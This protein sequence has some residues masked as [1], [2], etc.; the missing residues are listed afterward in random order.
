MEYKVYA[1]KYN[2]AVK[3]DLP[4]P[5]KVFW[6]LAFMLSKEKRLVLHSGPLPLFDPVVKVDMK[7]QSQNK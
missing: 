4:C 7:H 6:F 5:R 3:V 1:P 2:D